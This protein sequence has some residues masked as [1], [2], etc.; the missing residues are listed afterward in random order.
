MSAASTTKLFNSIKPSMS[1]LSLTSQQQ[2][3]TSSTATA[4][5]SS[6]MFFDDISADPNL[7]QHMTSSTT[8][9][10][11][12]AKSQSLF[13]SAFCLLGATSSAS[14]Q[15]LTLPNLIKSEETPSTPLTNT[16]FIDAQELKC[17][18]LSKCLIILDCRTYA[19]FN[20]KAISNSV[21]LN[22]RDKIIKKR[23]QAC[24]LTVKDL[25]SSE[26][27]K[28][29][30]DF[31]EECLMTNVK[32]GI[33]SL[34]NTSSQLLNRLTSCTAANNSLAP[35]TAASCEASQ[36]IRPAADDYKENARPLAPSSVIE[37]PD[38]SM[39]VI[40]DD[41]TSDLNEL[42]ADSN[43]LMIVQENIK[44]CG[45]KKECKVLKGT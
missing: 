36:E 25:I 29:K 9:T 43:P 17:K 6:S 38:D 13:K 15:Q 32:A 18:L 20:A 41:K 34:V 39:I 16:P 35:R 14:K 11:S 40:Y 1:T 28:K 26:E 19:D 3:S 30:F 33:V 4:T 31:G 24:K 22:C 45:Y 12:T 2:A 5:K 10:T 7:D 27:V 37:K 42:Q 44:Q 23:L 8:N 21:H